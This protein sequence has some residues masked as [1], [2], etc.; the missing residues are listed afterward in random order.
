[1]ARIETLTRDIEKIQ[2]EVDNLPAPEDIK[3]KLAKVSTQTSALDSKIR[4]VQVCSE[5]VGMYN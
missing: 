2:E 1:M 5:L 4:N 3:P